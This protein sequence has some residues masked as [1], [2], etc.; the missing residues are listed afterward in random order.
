MDA[1]DTPDWSRER[2]HGWE[3]SKALLASIRDYQAAATRSNPIAA[4]RKKLA[5][6]R[7]RFW[8]AVTGADI[9][10]N[11]QIAGGLVMPHPNGIVI[12]PDSVIGPNCMIFHQVTLGTD[13]VGVPRLAGNVRI[14][15]GAKLVGPIYVG[16][17]AQIGANAV[18]LHDVP[19]NA[20]VAG[21]PARIL[22]ITG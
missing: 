22:K 18:V 13:G 7:Y 17:N 5:V 3:P 16:A 11:A 14:G 6:L 20:T 9:P 15:A 8:S 10:L 21:I 1:A 19:A 2:R 4:L 12:H